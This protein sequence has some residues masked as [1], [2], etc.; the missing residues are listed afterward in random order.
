MS[1]FEKEINNL[2]NDVI[3]S[4]NKLL[5]GYMTSESAVEE[6][7]KLK[8]MIND[9]SSFLEY[10]IDR[11]AN[12]ASNKSKIELITS[13][14][15]DINNS[16][17]HD[18]KAAVENFNKTNDEQYIRDAVDI[19]VNILIPKLKELREL[20]Y[21][22]CIVEYNADTGTYH[23][24]QKKY[25]IEDIEFGEDIIVNEKEKTKSVTLE[26]DSQEDSQT[27]TEETENSFKTDKSS[28]VINKNNFTMT[29]GKIV[30]DNSDYQKIWN[31]LSNKYKNILA[32][33][34]NWMIET[35]DTYV[36]DYQNKKPRTFVRP[37]NLI[38]PP[39]KVSEEEYDFGNN[40]YNEVF[41]EL[42]IFQKNTLLTLYSKKDD[43]INY[44][45]FEDA[46][47]N[48]MM[49]YLEISKF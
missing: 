13:L 10:F 28:L 21:K 23:L 35:M 17:I 8:E 25:D 30:W 42:P 2:K 22:K 44:G 43:T 33:D 39:R 34:P 45:L 40:L 26:S 15:I 9:S 41:N 12:I 38:I 18:I 31:N 36:S 20:Q 29:N 24:I 3:D 48:I 19:Y 37:S 4:K 5:F 46:L 14:K 49:K 32:N 11:F 1:N 6:F 16:Y 27:N 47:D 7:D